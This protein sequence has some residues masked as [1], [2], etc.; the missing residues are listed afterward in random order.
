MNVLGLGVLTLAC[1][2]KMGNIEVDVNSKEN[3]GKKVKLCDH[4]TGCN[5]F[6]R[7]EI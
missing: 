3:W 6:L 5:D 1:S 2:V 7:K 4:N